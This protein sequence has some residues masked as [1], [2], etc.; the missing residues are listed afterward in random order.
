MTS[1]SVV[2]AILFVLLQS[3]ARPFAVEVS[4]DEVCA[5]FQ[6]AHSSLMIRASSLVAADTDDGSMRHLNDAAAAALA[7]SFSIQ[8][9]QDFSDFIFHKS[10][11]AVPGSHAHGSASSLSLRSL[12][13]LQNDKQFF[14]SFSTRSDIRTLLALHAF[15]GRR[16]VAHV[17]GGLY[18]AIGGDDFAAKARRFPGVA[19]V[20]ERDTL[21]KLGS[22]L[23]DALERAAVAENRRGSDS[24]I[25]VVAECWFDGCGAAAAAVRLLCPNVYL[26]PTLVE[27]HCR[28]TSLRAAVSVLSSHI[29]VDHVDLKQIAQLSNFGGRS[30]VG[31]GPQNA[32]SPGV[33]RV[34]STVN[35]SSSVIGVAD[36]G[37]DMNNCFFY[38]N[39]TH[40]PGNNSRV[41][42]AYTVLPCEVCGRCCR[43]NE[44]GPKC[45][46]ESNACGNYVDETAHG[47]HV[48]GTLAGSGPAA[49]QYGNGIAAGARIFFQDVEN[50]QS[51]ETCYL[52]ED[53]V[54]CSTITVPTDLLNLFA[55]AFDAGARVH[56]NSW[57]S[58][59]LTY[60]VQ[61][62]AAD[63]Y[64]ASNPTFLVLFAAGNTGNK[65]PKLDLGSNQVSCKNC[66]GVGA[67][68]QSD[69]LFR[70]MYPYVDDS[71]FCRFFVTFAKDECCEHPLTCINRCCNWT[72]AYNMSLD[73]C[74]DQTTCGNA[75]QCSV[76]SGNLRSATNIA[77]FSSR[78][79]T[80]DGRFKP[81]IVA[82]GEDILSAATPDQKMQILQGRGF[83]F[84]SSNHCDVPSKTRSRTEQELFD[85]ALR[86]SS[87]SSMATPLV[88]GAVEK[89]RQY[90]VQGYYPEGSPNSGAKFEPEEALVRAVVLASC[91]S[92]SSDPSWALW[93]QRIPLFQG[94]V[95]FPLPPEL[96]PNFFQ[97]FGLPV[98]DQA[99]HISGSTNGYRMFFAKG[100]FLPSSNASAFNITCKNDL[101]IPLTLALVWTDPPGSLN[102]QKQLVNDLD[103][104]VLF[105]GSP[106][107]QKFGNMRSFADQANSVE[108]I[109]TQC[110]PAGVVTAIVAL[111]DSIKT[112]N[113]TWYLVANGPVSNII[114]TSLPFYSSGRLTGA[115]TQP[116]SCMSDDAIAA[117]LRFK[118]SSSWSCDGV[119]GTLSCSTRR[120]VFATSLAQ[121]VGVAVQA[122]TVNKSDTTGL[123]MT[124]RCSAVINSWQ[125]ASAVYLKYVTASTVFAAISNVP[126]SSFQD[127]EVLGAFDWTSFAMAPAPAPQYNPRPAIGT[128]SNGVI[129]GIIGGF[130]F[131]LVVSIC[132]FLLLRRKRMPC[133]RMFRKTE[134]A[135][136]QRLVAAKTRSNQAGDT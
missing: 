62:R 107:S 118:P 20:Q 3:A 108:R 17:Q 53:E 121:I 73:C 12:G 32:S 122:I 6:L 92:V 59:D 132:V 21:S 18:V 96:S 43:G 54:R 128:L 119:S 19:W 1:R 51:N 30:I 28:T 106:L 8:D 123:L 85:R 127:D 23:Q 88:A 89:I 87:G 66:L 39:S 7:A 9:E 41:V 16:V 136:Q 100:V 78:G 55:P 33:S 48:V 115:S 37:I 99:V 22:R 50:V 70:S 71:N 117:I 65:D 29:A 102:G 69:F 91:V 4:A 116:L 74:P 35:V 14:V 101:T 130:V 67:T 5:T 36:S 2:A 77:A 94:F 40:P 126:K 25:E 97:G 26:H 125:N 110:P 120:K 56:S 76:E 109:V 112:S 15:T 83:K 104:V 82:P 68:Q 124:L 95:R 79:P 113:Q 90:F 134:V 34:L 80:S 63:A 133:L 58:S 13:G 135:L 49:L 64:I 61:Q 57:G 44:S 60:T 31:K 86:L 103:L 27:A 81:D 45:T 111:G 10:R 46:N 11:F 24:F 114:N 38:D 129:V 72:S 105:P 42:M 98:L 47:T 52:R 75:G 93:T 84:T 131:I